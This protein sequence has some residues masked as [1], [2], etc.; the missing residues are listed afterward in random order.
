MQAIQTVETVT[1]LSA[2]LPRAEFRSALAIVSKVA[3][4]RPRIPILSH[5]SLRW[6][7]AGMSASTTDLDLY[8]TA[9]IPGAASDRAFNAVLPAHALKD[10]ETRAPATDHVSMD[11]RGHDAP[12]ILDFEGLRASMPGLDP[13]DLPSYEFGKAGARV[14][15]SAADL[16]DALQRVM[17]AVSKEEVRYYLNGVYMQPAR[18]ERG[19]GGPVGLRFTATDG[20]RLSNMFVGCDPGAVRW[21]LRR[22]GGAVAQ[23]VII[24]LKAA[25]FA[26][27]LLKAKTAPETVSM[28][29]NARFIEIKIGLVDIVS[30]TIDGTFPD[31]ARVVPVSNPH[32]MVIGTEPLARAIEAVSCI[33]SERGRAVKM[34]LS[35]DSL[36]LTVNNP[37][38]G[39][40]EMD[41]ACAYD[42]P[43]MSIGFNA[44]YV[45]DILGS[46]ASETVAIDLADHM[47]PALITDPATPGAKCVLMPLRI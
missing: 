14:E 8:V 15:I 12:A 46:L 16:R 33:S 19:A 29:L 25:A 24:P 11:I 27:S 20:H 37:E 34:S 5:V 23:G 3:D 47:S 45:L 18:R 28:R 1:T 38:M 10:M 41:V 6:D 21:N 7:D 32:R 31:Y 26:L 43:P 36:R 30:K 44:K 39:A 35:R 40:T 4:K 9:R 13:S 2:L 42:G 22:Q 17:F